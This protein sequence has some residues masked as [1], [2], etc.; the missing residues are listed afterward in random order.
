MQTSWKY[1][2]VS[3]QAQ[4]EGSG[5]Y[6][7][8][9]VIPLL[10]ASTMSA[11]VSSKPQL[12]PT[13]IFPRL[14]YL[15]VTKNKDIGGPGTLAQKVAQLIHRHAPKLKGFVPIVGVFSRKVR[16][17]WWWRAQITWMIAKGGETQISPVSAVSFPYGAAALTRRLE[18]LKKGKSK[19]E[20]HKAREEFRAQVK[21]QFQ[22][23]YSK[24]QVPK[25]LVK[26]AMKNGGF[27]LY[28]T[29]GGFRGWGYLLLHHEQV[30][31]GGYPF[32]IINGFTAQKDEFEDTEKMKEIAREAK[33]IFRVS[34]R[35]RGQVPAVSFLVSVLAEAIPH[36]IREAH[37]CQGGVRE[38]VLYN[39]LPAEIRAQD[40]LE[41]AT[42]DMAKPISPKLAALVTQSLPSGTEIHA[43]VPESIDVH[44]I[45]AFANMFYFHA[46]MNKEVSSTSALYSTGTGILCS[47]HGSSHADR[48][49]LALMLEARYEGELAPRETDYRDQLI[50]LVSNEE[51]WWTQYIGV[52]GLILSRAFPAGVVQD[53]L[54]DM[55]TSTILKK[56]EI[57]I[58]SEYVDTLGKR[59]DKEG[60][61]VTF[62]LVW[63]TENRDDPMEV[64][65]TLE[66]HIKDLVKVGRKKHAD[67]GWGFGDK[68][69]ARLPLQ[70]GFQ[71]GEQEWSNWS[72]VYEG[73]KKLEQEIEKSG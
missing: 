35:R 37:F 5:A 63:Q 32:S 28:L 58:S 62:T 2:Y 38:G 39:R 4:E 43:G 65:E 6:S 18:E 40:P 34:D 3:K 19:H 46:N 53:D 27:R 7:K 26:D 44:M 8:P 52:I 47:T 66:R 21:T 55:H 54:Y 51:A 16:R 15:C 57:R 64:K 13:A 48:A 69:G 29:G 36:G 67:Q 72:G 70:G 22:E 33:E 42:R 24:I 30:A 14:A 60:L 17:E 71:G 59:G 45:R 73:L 49:L 12:M 25:E 50:R 10:G 68:E 20:A 11:I 9:S 23:A 1:K 31:G 56:P 41:V 61:M